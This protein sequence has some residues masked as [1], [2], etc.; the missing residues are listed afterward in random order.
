MTNL[1]TDDFTDAEIAIELRPADA[2]AAEL[3]KQAFAD[4]EVLE[5]DAFTGTEILTIITS[6]GKGAI[7]KFL[8]FFAKHRERFKGA[9]VKIGTK[10][11]ALTGYSMEEVQNLLSSGAIQKIQ[12][13][14]KKK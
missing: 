8:D 12:R 3:V 5:S 10:E 4:E 6:L 2:D 7:G 11:V 9:T 1:D 14:M 13:E